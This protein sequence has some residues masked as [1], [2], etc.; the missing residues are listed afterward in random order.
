MLP[1]VSFRLLQHLATWMTSFSTA[2][3]SVPLAWN[4][5]STKYTKGSWC[6][7]HNQMHSCVSETRLCSSGWTLFGGQVGLPGLST[8]CSIIRMNYGR[9]LVMCMR[10]PSTDTNPAWGMFAEK[11]SHSWQQSSRDAGQGGDR[12]TSKACAWHI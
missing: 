2:G 6:L 7:T 5:S 8:G 1:P 4:P 3:C 11:T 10:V 12:W 9:G